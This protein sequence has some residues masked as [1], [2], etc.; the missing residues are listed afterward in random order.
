MSRDQ[1]D[2][3]MRD[4]RDQREHVLVA[5]NDLTEDDFA[6]PTD[7]VRWTEV[8]RVLLRLGDHM[9]EHSTQLAG[10]RAAIDRPPTMPQRI[11]AEAEHAWGVLR[12]ALVGLTDADLDRQPPDGWTLR[13]TLAHI[14]ESERA[15]LAAILR[16]LEEAE[17]RGE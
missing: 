11:L 16:A 12:A 10:I 14:A 13:E 1:L 8:R 3:I 6:T 17:E 15:Y 5:L 7:M 4:L 9:R 2:Q